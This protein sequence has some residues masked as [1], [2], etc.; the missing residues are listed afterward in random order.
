MTST[1]DSP[2]AYLSAAGTRANATLPLTWF[3]LLVSVAVCLII[4]AILL[5][6]IQ[7]R[8]VRGTA[9]IAA[10]PVLRDEGGTRWISVG[11]ILS[12]I[13]LAVAFIWTMLVLAA[14][15]GP[16]ASPALV[17]DI[18]ARQWW[19]EVQ[20]T[21]AQPSETF[22]TANEIHIP[23]GKPVLV[24]LHAADVIH[25]F[26]V[27]KLSGKTDLF[28]GQTNL[29]WLQADQPGRYLGQCSEF[30]GYQHAHMQFEV[31]AETQAEFDQWRTLQRQPAARVVAPEQVRGLT[32]LESRCALCH[33]VN[34]TDA[35]AIIAPDL[36][37]LMSRRTIAAGT[38]L[39]NPGNL[40]GWIQDPQGIKPGSRMPNQ[41][42][43]S[44]ELSD[45]LAYLE[46]LR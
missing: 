42:L 6:A 29:S 22:A 33:R 12:A 38:L 45:A 25:S 39:N 11:L 36:T 17:I 24:R 40:L 31:V 18:T 23:A 19:W 46:T 41:Y 30:C 28:P 14:V 1:A 16:P 34:G 15:A 26:W 13:P 9:E 43:S 3:M 8:R 10:V 4:G 20:Y 44:Q 37:H 21:S 32:L 2:L 27:P 7:R 5:V 35:G